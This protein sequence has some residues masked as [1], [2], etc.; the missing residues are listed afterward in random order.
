ML[1]LKTILLSVFNGWMD[2][3]RFLRHSGALFQRRSPGRAGARICMLAHSL[4]KGLSLR[5]KRPGF[6]RAKAATLLE[7]LEGYASHFQPDT[8]VARACAVLRS[9]FHDQKDQGACLDELA[10][11]FEPLEALL[12]SVEAVNGG[13]VEVRRSEIRRAIAGVDFGEFIRNRHSIRSFEGSP[14]SLRKIRDAIAQ[15]RK[16]PSVCNRQPWRVHVW[17]RPESI[18]KMLRHQN[19]NRGFGHEG[20]VL[21]LVTC[22]LENFVSTE[23]R[24]EP[25]VDGGMFAMSLVYALHGLGLGCCC[26][27]LCQQAYQSRETARAG[28]IPDREMLIMMILVGHLPPSVRVARSAR[29]PVRDLMILH[30]EDSR[31]EAADN[32]KKPMAEPSCS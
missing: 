8:T 12:G 2:T 6:A 7:E 27:N 29:M 4:E 17:H 20:S 21:L 15:A 18:R 11:R 19:G 9:Y 10:E 23:E 22:D 14:V 26:L 5:E 13:V 3:W 1:G 16:T 30:D 25:Y 31:A 24:N 32:W 28:G